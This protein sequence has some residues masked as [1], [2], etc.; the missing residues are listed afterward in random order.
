MGLNFV[1][2]GRVR[3][4][5]RPPPKASSQELQ[6]RHQLPGSS[7]AAASHSSGSAASFPSI[8]WLPFFFEAGVKIPAVMPLPA[9]IKGLLLPP[10]RVVDESATAAA[11]ASPTR[12]PHLTPTTHFPA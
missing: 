10:G 9:R 11:P 7:F 6:S 12:L 3:A 4:L 2:P 5:T 8:Q 1:L